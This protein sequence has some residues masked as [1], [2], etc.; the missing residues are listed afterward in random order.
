M[1]GLEVLARPEE[2]E[3]DVVFVGNE[4][5]HGNFDCFL[6]CLASALPSDSFGARPTLHWLWCFLK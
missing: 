6:T 2:V 1:L 3:S 5:E 4:V